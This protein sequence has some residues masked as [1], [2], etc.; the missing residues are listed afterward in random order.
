MALYAPSVCSLDLMS[1]D[2]METILNGAFNVI[3]FGNV[4]LLCFVI[5]R[6]VCVS[7]DFDR[8]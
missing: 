2:V 7:D 5:V 8:K 6:C 1:F 3:S 4:C